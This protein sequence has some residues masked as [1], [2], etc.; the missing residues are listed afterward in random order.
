MA[1]KK[2][3][4]ISQAFALS[5]MMTFA[6]RGAVIDV[7]PGGGALIAAYGRAAPGDT[8]RLLPG[9]HRGPLIINKSLTLRGMKGAALI[10][11]GKGSVIT[12]RAPDVVID[13]LT[14]SGSGSLNQNIDAGVKLIKGA[15][16][17]VV[18][19]NHFIGNLVG[20]DIHGAVDARVF[21]NTIIGRTDHRMNDRGNGI[22]V[23]NAPGAIVEG[24][25][26][27][28][29]RDGIFVN[30]SRQD[31]FRNNRMEDLRFA[32]HYMYTNDSEV[33]GNISVGNH[34]G[35]ALMFS[36]GLVVRRNISLG[37]RDH[38]LMLNFANS[39]RI[40][41][42][43]VR[44]GKNKCLFLYN[45]NKNILCKNRFEHCK[46]GIHFTAG[47]ERNQISENA[48]IS[49][50]T[51]V[52]YVG[53]RDLDWSVKG[54]GNFW[55]DHTAV[56][57]NG[58]GIADQAYRPNDAIDRLLWTQPSAQLLL[59]SPAVQLVRWAQATFPSLLPG[60]IIDTAPLM[61]PPDLSAVEALASRG[62]VGG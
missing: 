56:D 53:T 19:N 52:K 8:L 27:H 49:N 21:N 12:V 17:A 57:I 20:V 22:Y 62:G 3:V 60:G 48:F 24:N 25:V 45:S 9:V 43:I 23:W 36:S 38:G 33:S 51:Q 10:G 31:I 26:I 1:L 4:L 35:F 39:S 32:I 34:I 29:G 50:R 40:E 42:N 30:T 28:Y 37:D 59:G 41:E 47:S 61:K 55:S 58:D 11:G 14:L 7:P 5:A 46:I 13:S 6:A 15:D 2:I 54:T 44:D 16:R 18:E